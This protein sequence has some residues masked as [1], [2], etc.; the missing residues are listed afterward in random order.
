M[1]KRC[2]NCN[3]INF[4]DLEVCKRCG[5]SLDLPA[6][7]PA[8]NA[9][10][11]PPSTLN[12]PPSTPAW[13][14]RPPH[15]IAEDGIIAQ[16]IKRTNRS[17]KVMNLVIVLAVAGLALLN[18]KYL[19]H[20]VAGPSHVDYSTLFRLKTASGLWNDYVKVDGTNAVETGMEEIW[21]KK[22]NGR[23]VEEKT[24]AR[25]YLLTTDTEALLVKVPV[26]TGVR[27][28]TG[29]VVDMPSFEKQQ[30]LPQLYT[31]E[32]ELRSRLRPVMLNAGD[33]HEA[34]WAGLALGIP[35]LGLG[36]W[37][38]KKLASRKREPLLHPVMRALERFGHP[39][40]VA[41]QI[42]ADVRAHIVSPVLN[43]AAATP[44]WLLHPSKFGLQVLAM[45]ELVWAYKHVTRHY[46]NFVPTGKTFRL[47]VADRQGR[48]LSLDGNE[49][50][51]D[52][53]LGYL[54]Q[55]A[56]WALF[57][58]DPD[59]ATAWRTNLSAVVHTVDR[60]R[61]QYEEERANS[62]LTEAV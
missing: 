40:V 7:G 12:A 54:R 57:G 3:L 31:Q 35:L 28:L 60:R 50:D 44:T 22:R 47:M 32:P 38:L 62:E 26:G 36:L 18:I 21:K 56:P 25:Y 41:A 52:G 53:L 11:A 2:G 17:L 9:A 48:L 51:T 4:A 30:I 43:K 29:Q 33:Y 39:N 59:L 6:A 13:P 14:S 23:V 5:V 46:T 34:G 8:T 37:N 16:H 20:F 61:Q 45:A 55:V 15:G 42:D 1:N 58:Y 49:Y 10:Y 27:T 19:Y 24:T